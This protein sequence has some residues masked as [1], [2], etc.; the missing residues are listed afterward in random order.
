MIG[1]PIYKE[2]STMYRETKLKF[3]YKQSFDRKIS[4]TGGQFEYFYF[5]FYS[6]WHLSK[7]SL[8]ICRTLSS[9][10]NWIHEKTYQVGQIIKEED[11][12]L[13]ENWA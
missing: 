11:F 1:L 2:K 7:L 9:E 13:Q 6:F 8:W 4:Y 10:L 3:H 12:L 5:A